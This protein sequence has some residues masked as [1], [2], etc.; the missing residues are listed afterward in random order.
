[1]NEWVN[2]ELAER[3]FKNQLQELVN[4]S[5]ITPEQKSAIKDKY[6]DLRKQWI[7][8]KTEALKIARQIAWVNVQPKKI[9]WVFPKQGVVPK[10]YLKTVT[11]ES[12]SW[13]W[14]SEYSAIMD[15]VDSGEIFL[16][17]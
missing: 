4:D 11:M 1:M 7:S 3:D 15:K 13:L 9:V 12:L 16:K 17:H 14:Q 8:S 10:S 6:L 5:E 2:S